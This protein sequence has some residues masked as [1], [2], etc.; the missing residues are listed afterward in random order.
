MI[1][2]PDEAERWHKESNNV[3]VVAVDNETELATLAASAEFDAVQVARFTEPDLGD[4]LT[5]IAMLGDAAR[6][7]CS[8]L[9][10]AGR[11]TAAV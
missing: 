2:F 5:A 6:R 11:E 3:V 1:E 8:R 7:W 10:L 4:E 9:P